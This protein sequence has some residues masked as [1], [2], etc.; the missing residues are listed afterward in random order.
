MEMKSVMTT[1]QTVLMDV[2]RPV[3]SRPPSIALIRSLQEDCRAAAQLASPFAPAVR[4]QLHV[5]LARPIIHTR[6]PTS[7]AISTAQ[8]LHIA[9]LAIL[10]ELSTA[11][12]AQRDT[13]SVT[14]FVPADAEMGS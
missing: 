12:S 9:P 13:M 2:H 1:I 10:L 7:A 11:K 5:M 6:L 14:T 3:P 8:I 4:M